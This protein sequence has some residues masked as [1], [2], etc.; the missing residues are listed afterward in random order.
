MPVDINPGYTSARKF[1]LV[2][3]DNEPLSATII[4]VVLVAVVKDVWSVIA[5]GVNDVVNVTLAVPLK[6][7]AGAVTT[8]EI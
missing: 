5:A 8:P 6:G 7:T 4:V 1:P 3:L 2:I